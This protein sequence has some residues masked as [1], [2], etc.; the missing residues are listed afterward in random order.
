MEIL[1]N[2]KTLSVRKLKAGTYKTFIREVDILKKL[3][4][5]PNVVRLIEI[6]NQ[7]VTDRHRDSK[8]VPDRFTEYLIFEFAEHELGSVL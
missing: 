3:P 6:L 7:P 4:P 8:E 2:D 5:H 1:E